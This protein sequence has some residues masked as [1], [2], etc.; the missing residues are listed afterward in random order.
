MPRERQ[1]VPSHPQGHQ[2]S[3]EKP[4]AIAGHKTL[5]LPLPYIQLCLLLKNRQLQRRLP[6]TWACRYPFNIDF[7]SFGYIPKSEAAGRGQLYFQLF[8]EPPYCFPQWSHQFTFPP[9]EYKRPTFSISSPTPL[10]HLLD[11]SHSNR[12][13]LTAT[14]VLTC[15]SLTV[16]DVEHLFMYPLA[17]CGSS[18]EKCPKRFG[19]SKA[20]LF[21]LPC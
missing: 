12:C 2:E 9:T 3:Q 11:D 10:P 1:L 7:V 5:S 8:E 21:S 20:A 13:E 15:I 19:S 16:S 14:V 17:M 18:L 6:C 4:E